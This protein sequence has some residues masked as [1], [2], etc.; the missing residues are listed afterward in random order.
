MRVA[1][2]AFVRRL[3][4]TCTAFLGA[5]VGEAAGRRFY[6]IVPEHLLLAMLSAEECDARRLL[7]HAEL[8]VGHLRGRVQRV[9]EQMR[10]GNAGRP[11]FA[12]SLFQWLEDAWV[13]ASLYFGAGEIRSGHLLLMYASLGHR[14][15][16]EVHPELRTL[17]VESLKRGFE[18]IT[19]GTKEA[20]LASA[21]SPGPVP[22][23]ASG[24]AAQGED[25]LGRFTTSYTAKAREGKI[26]P[27]F[28]RHEEIRQLAEILAR[29]RKNNPIIVG[30]PG[31][32]KTALVEGDELADAELAEPGE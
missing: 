28:G 25:A 13:L 23:T 1:P 27:V 9:L 6:E 26:D 14:Y 30:E 17:P 20:A 10:T 15:S 18:A 12:E 4:S 5:A 16:A 21:A 24:S 22:A 31:V 2:K 19:A 7:L 3:N 8:D 32:G 29:R 11:V